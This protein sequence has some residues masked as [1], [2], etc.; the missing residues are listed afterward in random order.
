MRGCSTNC[1]KSK[2]CKVHCNNFDPDA[3]AIDNIEPFDSFGYGSID[4]VTYL[5]GPSTNYACYKRI[6]TIP[7]L[8]EFVEFLIKNLTTTVV[9]KH[10]FPDDYISYGTLEKAVD[11]YIDH[12]EYKSNNETI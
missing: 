5:C 2:T 9:D 1:A 4:S 3:P 10:G 11:L 12:L 8:D 6:T 7:Q